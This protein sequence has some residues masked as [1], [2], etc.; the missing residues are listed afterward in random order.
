MLRRR[1][2]TG[3]S[4]YRRRCRG[5]LSC[6]SA[7]QPSA[8]VSTLRRAFR[9]RS[10]SGWRR[11]PD[12]RSPR[13]ATTSMHRARVTG[14]SKPPVSSGPSPSGYTKPSTICAGWAPGRGRPGRDQAADLQPGSSIMPGKVITVVPEAVAMVC[15]G[16]WQRRRGRVGRAA[17][18]AFELNVMLPDVGPQPARV[19]QLLADRCVDGIEANVERNR[20]YAESSPSIVTPLN[21]YIGYENAAAVAKKAL[22]HP[23]GDRRGGLCRARRSATARSGST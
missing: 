18:G 10:S 6:R 19:D 5:W 16:R 9:S 2:R 20:K 1:S 22:D 23:R 4:G 3:S 15:A 14:W 7:A 17:P 12:F 13:L 11:R 8:L 21:R